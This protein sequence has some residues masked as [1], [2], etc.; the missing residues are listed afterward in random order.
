MPRRTF[1]TRLIQNG[2][3]QRLEEVPSFRE[4]CPEARR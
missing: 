4:Q 2:I 3:H 1:S